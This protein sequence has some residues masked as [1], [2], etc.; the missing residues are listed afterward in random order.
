MS[1]VEILKSPSALHSPRDAD[2]GKEAATTTIG[3]L[4]PSALYEYTRSS[5]HSCMSSTPVT[6]TCTNPEPESLKLLCAR[7]SQ[8][9]PRR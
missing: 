3:D 8:V 6:G 2:P 4:D 5:V 9:R 7:T 1:G